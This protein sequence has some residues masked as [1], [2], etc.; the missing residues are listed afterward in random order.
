M[1]SSRQADDPVVLLRESQLKPKPFSALSRME[2][3]VREG[4]ARVG[5]ASNIDCLS[6]SD[7]NS[8]LEPLM[9]SS[10]ESVLK[11]LGPTVIYMALSL[12]LFLALRPKIPRVYSPKAL[13]SIQ[14][15]R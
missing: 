4:D 12:V 14:A 15:P 11:I 9:G 7:R 3:S 1:V 8:S 2:R 6:K 10:L 13:E 5:N